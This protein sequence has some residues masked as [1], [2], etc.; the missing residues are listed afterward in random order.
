MRKDVITTLFSAIGTALLI[1]ANWI[2]PSRPFWD[3]AIAAGVIMLASRI[4]GR[5]FGK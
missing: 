2:S 3:N 1:Q 4:L 5:M